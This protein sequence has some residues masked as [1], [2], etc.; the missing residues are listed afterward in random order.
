M[1][2]ILFLLIIKAGTLNAQVMLPSYQGVQ[3][4]PLSTPSLTT[5][6]VTAATATT[7][8][9]GGNVTLAGATSVT[10]RGVCWSL[11]TG[12][13]IADG[14]TN[15]GTGTGSFASTIT[16]LTSMTT[17][18][19]RAYATNSLGTAYGDELT[20]TTFPGVGSTYQGGKIV[21][22]LVSTDAGYDPLVPHGF[23]V[24]AVD[25][26]TGTSWSNNNNNLNSTN[27]GGGQANTTAIVADQGAGGYAAKL[28]NDYSVV[29]SDGVTYSGW[30][31][32]N[33]SEL[34]NLFN[35][36]GTTNAGYA[37]Q[38]YWSSSQKVSTTAS[39]KHFGTGNPQD[40]AK[41]STFLAVRAVRVF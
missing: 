16:G 18:Y 17:Y 39:A 2:Y 19:I 14:T 30:Y 41:N 9:T 28:C 24:S 15:D 23:M 1:R 21:S 11:S 7:I 3:V 13:T 34:T 20:F 25:L 37:S 38:Y 31:L 35:N 32:P 40:Y 10:A 29:G 33:R 12:P 5:A 4:V 27:T 22:L 36:K 8:T 6:S 26:S